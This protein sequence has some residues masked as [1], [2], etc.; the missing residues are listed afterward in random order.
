MGC[1]WFIWLT[2]LNCN[3]VRIEHWLE[4]VI[5]V[6]HESFWTETII[7]TK[8]RISQKAKIAP[9]AAFFYNL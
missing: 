8:V 7:K 3:R 5:C 2:Y 1:S 4:H 9:T 6:K